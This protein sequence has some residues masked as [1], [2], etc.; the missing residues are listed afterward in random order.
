MWA[1][2]V[3]IVGASTSQNPMGLHRLLQGQLFF[4]FYLFT[5]LGQPRF[6]PNDTGA[7]FSTAKATACYGS[8]TSSPCN[9]TSYINAS[10]FYSGA[11]FFES[12]SGHRLPWYSSWFSPSENM[13]ESIA[14]IRPLISSYALILIHESLTIPWF[15]C[16]QPE[17]VTMSLHEP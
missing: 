15:D 11:S 10:D 4:T 13:A 3:E 16:L 2:C 12:R 6:L 5:N 1:H 8:T 14:K 9:R 17:T 7:S